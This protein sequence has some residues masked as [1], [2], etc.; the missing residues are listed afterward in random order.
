MSS[1]PDTEDDDDLRFLLPQGVGDTEDVENYRKGGFHPVHLG[2]ELDNGRYKI[3]HKLGAGGFSTVWIAR[4]RS[5]ND[6]VAVKIVDAKHSVLNAKKNAVC[7]DAL[8][9]LQAKFVVSEIRQFYH[10]GPNGRHL[11]IVLPILGPSASELSYGLTCRLTPK[12]AR[13]LSYQAAQAVCELHSHGV[14]HGGQYTK[15]HLEDLERK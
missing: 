1:Y 11:C 7:Q 2:D 4:D 14:C 10:D 8:D 12:I 9:K 6:W 13:N 5:E 3:L 15:Q